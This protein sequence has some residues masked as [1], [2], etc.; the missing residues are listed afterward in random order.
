MEPEVATDPTSGDM[1]TLLALV[2]VQVRTTVSPLSIDDL[3]ELNELTTGGGTGSG[4]KS[5]ISGG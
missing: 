3:L 2:V 4:V 1:V 5:S